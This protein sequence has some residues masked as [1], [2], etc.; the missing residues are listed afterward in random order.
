MNFAQQLLAPSVLAMFAAGAGLGDQPARASEGNTHTQM[1]EVR[2]PAESPLS[3]EEQIT[4]IGQFTDVA[5]DDWAYQALNALVE[6]YGCVAGYPDGRFLGHRSISRFEAAALLNACLDRVS[7]ITDELRR[8]LLEFEAELALI[9]GR[10]DGLEA[11]VGELDVTQFSTTTKLTGQISFAFGANA[12]KG[13]ARKLVKRNR[14]DFGAAS[15]NYDNQLTLLTSFTGKDLLTTT[16]RAGNFGDNNSLSS[17]GPSNFSA[18]ETAYQADRGPNNIQIDKIFY[19]FPI[20]SDVNITVGANVGQDDMLPMWP[21]IYPSDTVL[22]LVYLNGAPTAYNKNQGPG[23][24]V[25]WSIGDG[26]SITANYVAAQGNGGDASQGGIA[27]AGAAGTGTLQLGYEAENWSVAGIYTNIQNGHGIVAY[28][29]QLGLESFENPGTTNAFGL[30][31]SW[32][33]IDSGWIPS[34][35]AGWGFNSTVYDAGTSTQGLVKDSQSWMVGLQWGDV[36]Q[37]GTNI[38]VAVGQPFFA[39]SLYGDQTP[40]DGNYVCEGWVQF[41]VSDNITVTPAFFYLSRPLG[42]HTPEGHSFQQLGGV[43]MTTFHF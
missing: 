26:F 28:A 31:G 5:P 8:L 22:D 2:L 13:S 41:Q 24:G 16:L 37:S 11:R 17:G 3:A 15:V 33:P 34:V 1:A 30:S 9:R 10:V 20:G 14:R 21:W 38:G 43:L 19:Q 18:L 25:T 39:S 32:Q 40:D 23:A 6:R 7:D 42:Q 4:T 29:T 35:S 12:F 36:A 27:T